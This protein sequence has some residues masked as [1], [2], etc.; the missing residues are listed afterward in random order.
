MEAISSSEMSV[1]FQRTTRRYI[2][3][4]ST[5]QEGKRFVLKNNYYVARLS[6]WLTVQPSLNVILNIY[7]EGMNKAFSYNTA[8][9]WK[10]SHH[11]T[12]CYLSSAIT[13]NTE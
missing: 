4:D 6:V 11:D 3:E 9:S 8:S 12:L 2:P 7:V 5:L 1:D 10:P 13:S